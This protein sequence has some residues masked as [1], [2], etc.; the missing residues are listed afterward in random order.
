MTPPFPY[1]PGGYGN[2]PPAPHPSLPGLPSNLQIPQQGQPPAGAGAPFQAPDG[3]WW[4]RDAQGVL[5]PEHGGGGGDSAGFG[6]A[7]FGG[8]G[9]GQRDTSNFTEGGAPY[10]HQL[11]MQLPGQLIKLQHSATGMPA[12]MHTAQP[13]AASDENRASGGNLIINAPMSGVMSPDAGAKF[14]NKI[15]SGSPGGTNAPQLS[16][17]AGAPVRT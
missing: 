10:L 4:Y 16:G 2:N 14:V 8:G 15:V 12:S 7:G 1:G 9:G 13:Q 17:G 5:H 3:S 6:G 11:A